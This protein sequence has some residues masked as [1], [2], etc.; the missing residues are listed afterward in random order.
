MRSV[1]WIFF[2]PEYYMQTFFPPN[3]LNIRTIKTTRFSSFSFEQ[4]LHADE[5]VSADAFDGNRR[6]VW[7]GAVHLRD[8]RIRAKTGLFIDVEFLSTTSSTPRDASAQPSSVMWCEE[9]DKSTRVK[10]TRAVYLSSAVVLIGPRG[11][12]WT[13]R[14][15]PSRIGAGSELIR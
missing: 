5:G 15:G 10:P 2:A 13:D 7:L 4:Q 6:R 14:Y 1:D 9:T 8:S 3:N 11:C 12:R